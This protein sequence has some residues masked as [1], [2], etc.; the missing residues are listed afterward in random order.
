MPVI[1][2]HVLRNNLFVAPMAGVTDRP[3]RQLCKRLGAGYAVSEMV[4]SNAQ[5][6]KSA[7]TMRRAN[8]EGEVEPIAVQIAGADPAMM[9]EAA[10]YNVD[11][12]AQIID[13][14]MGCPA[15]K[16]CNVAAGSALLQNEP[17]VKQI[18]EAVV[19]A[20]GT[21]PGAVPVTLKIRTGWDREHK[22]AITVA[23]LAEAAGISMLTVHGRTRADLYRGEAEYETIA[24]VK[25]A[26]GIPV[27]ANGDITS[28]QKAKAVLDATGADALMIGRAA[29]GRPWLF[30]EIDH[31]LQTAELLPPPLIDEIQQVM[32]EHLEDHY[33]FYGE[34][35]GVRTARKHIG[36]YTR[37]L[38]GANGFRHRMNTLD[39][40]RE[41]LA[42]VNA[43]FE[44]Q[45]A[46]SD[47]LV[48]VDEDGDDH[49]ESD[50]HNQLAA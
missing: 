16:V 40:T 19:G 38:S 45:K 3:F 13:I 2:S 10:R 41:Q 23:R 33:A 20:V 32:N 9:A 46:L 28:P 4:A 29:Q 6:W 22:N 15:K 24:A 49:G 42:A 48:Y 8:H 5:L 11:N 27:V 1:G 12:G 44:A 50:D 36:W 30:R 35:T 17:L 43:F 25:A 14:N 26:V 34:F 18:V 7:K 37:G 21:G 47:H 39:S 31:F